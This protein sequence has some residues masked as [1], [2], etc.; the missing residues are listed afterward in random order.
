VHAIVRRYIEINELTEELLAAS[1]QCRRAHWD[2]HLFN[3]QKI[4]WPEW[5]MRTKMAENE[6][7]FVD[8]Q[9]V[10]EQHTEAYEHLLRALKSEPVALAGCLYKV[11][12]R[13]HC[14]AAPAKPALE[15]T[16]RVVA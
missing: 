12:H 15:K 1:R 13:P 4:Q 6:L 11:L 8:A 2:M 7:T 3:H 9:M 16:N 14:S 5:E 10:L